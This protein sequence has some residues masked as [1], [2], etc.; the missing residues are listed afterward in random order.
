MT[1]VGL[2]FPLTATTAQLYEVSTKDGVKYKHE[3]LNVFHGHK[4]WIAHV[5]WTHDR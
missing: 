2:G 4:D 3:I 1:N 5:S